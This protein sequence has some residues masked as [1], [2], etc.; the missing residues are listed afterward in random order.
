MGHS[1][2]EEGGSMSINR[3]ELLA[4]I[5]GLAATPQDVGKMTVWFVVRS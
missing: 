1:S 3:R 5:G 4:G 2:N